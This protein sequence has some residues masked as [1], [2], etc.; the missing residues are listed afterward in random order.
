M[1][2]IHTADWHLGKIIFSHSML[3]LQTEFLEDFLK[4][5]II[6]EKPDAFVLAGDI[7]DRSI[8]PPE[9]IRMFDGFIEFITEL[10]I[11]LLSITGN[12]DGAERITLGA[13]ILKQSGIHI[14][15][16]IKN[17]LEPV[18]LESDGEKFCFYLIPHFDPPA[19][20]EF[21]GDDSIRGFGESYKALTDR[22]Y[23]QL[24]RRCVN[25]AVSHCF[26]SG[27]TVSDSE[28]PVYIGASGEVS[29]D[30]FSGFDLTLLGHLHNAQTAGKNGF[31]SGSPLKYSFGEQGSQKGVNI[32]EIRNGK[33]QRRFVPFTPSLDMR[34]ISG[35]FDKLCEYGR[36]K[37]SDDYIHIHLTD[38]K[39]I[40]MPL[41]R[42]REFYPNILEMSS[43][44]LAAP[45]ENISVPS[46]RSFGES[47]ELFCEFSKQIC[48]VEADEEEIELF[49]KI[50]EEALR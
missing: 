11:P 44:L 21:F 13:S 12:H 27:C 34:V 7:F 47:V 33:T 49:R 23:K 2:L 5:L 14:A 10:N 29:G 18:V 31:Y 9:A 19:A 17:A 16:D 4:P 40:F 15:T 1:K 3:E 43:E 20:R 46:K 38:K 36:E 28:S 48:G 45:G 22:I 24:D 8:A 50:A 37:P 35:E 32:F 30:L 42:L 25:I 6:L 39:P 26:M 41:Q